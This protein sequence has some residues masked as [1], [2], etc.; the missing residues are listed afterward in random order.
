LVIVL[1]G[2]RATLRGHVGRSGSVH[3]P[4]LRVTYRAAGSDAMGDIP[5]SKVPVYWQ[6]HMG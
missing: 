3:Q 4:A 2:L 1:S 5:S 6:S